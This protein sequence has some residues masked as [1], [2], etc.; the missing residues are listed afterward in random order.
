MKSLFYTTIAL[1]T[2]FEIANV[3]FIMPMPGSQRMETINIAYFLFTWRWVFRL[4]LTLMAVFALLKS[5]FRRPWQPAL[6]ILIWGF[7]SYQFNFVMTADKMFIQPTLTL[8]NAAE[9]KVD[10]GRIALCIVLNGE[11]KAYPIQFMAYHHQVRDTIGAQ[12]VMVTYCNVC[13]SGR[14]FEPSVNGKAETFRLVG[15]DHF[16]AMFEDSSTGSWWRQENGEAVAGPLR[17][18]V[19]PELPCWQMSLG[20]WIRLYPNTLIMQPDST[21]A[22]HYEKQQDFETGKKK[23]KLTGTDS[24]SWA[25]K[26]WVVGVETPETTR[27]FDWNE[28]K[29]ARILND[30]VGETPVAIALAGDGK[31]FAVFERPGGVVFSL[32]N[33]T[34][35]GGGYRYDFAGRSLHG[36][37]VN[38][39]PLPAYQEFWHSWRVFHE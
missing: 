17:G 20:Q 28:L 19:L 30:M 23:G 32:Q 1:L 7:V 31:S 11:A 24:L 29:N 35:I 3:Y 2:L 33:D 37:T 21:F 38:L 9:N 14:M 4:G 25:E 36:E 22:E 26:S 39:R 27:A 12:P 6:A 34:L 13:R 15:M 18:Q 8:K 16:N 10:T 5:D